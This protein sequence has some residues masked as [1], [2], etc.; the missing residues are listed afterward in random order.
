MTVDLILKGGKAA[1]STGVTEANISIDDGE[2]VSLSKGLEKN[3]ERKA[4]RVI[5]CKNKLILPGGIDFHVHLMD[6]G[7]ADRE[8]WKSG[9]E[10][11]AAGGTTFVVDHGQTNPPS[12]SRKNLLEIKNAAE[13]KAIVDFRINGNITSENLDELEELVEEGVSTFGEIYMAESIPELETVQTGTLLEAFEKISSLDCLAGVHAEDRQIVSHLTE[14]LKKEERKDLSAHLESRPSIAEELAVFKA[15][16]F[17][18]TDDLPLHIY[19]LTTEAGLE[20]IEEAKRNGQDVSTEATPHHLLFESEDLEKQG[21]YLKCNP[22][23]RTAKNREALWRGLRKG[24]ID[25][26][27][28]DHYPLPKSEKE[29]GWGDIWKAGAGMP[30]V[31]TRIPLLLTYGVKA[32]EIS[33]KT[34]LK[35]IAENPARRLNLYPKKGTISVGSDADLTVVDLNEKTEINA[36]EL[37]TKCDYTPFEGWEVVGVPI[38]TLVRGKIVME[39]GEIVPE[40]GHGKF[41]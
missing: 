17:A 13:N 37:H 23:I 4:D 7:Y 32:D 14:K 5:D 28:T 15:L 2:I 38:L 25:M 39:N 11:A 29:I 24:T 16:L 27:S 19:H 8:D 6:L 10:S 41:F 35:V 3:E 22:P 36:E 30:G 33:M 18:R 12:T 9:T 40:P 34:F 20:L 1:L 21:P 26:I 31:E